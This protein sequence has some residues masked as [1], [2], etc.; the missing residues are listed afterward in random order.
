MASILIVSSD[1]DAAQELQGVAREAGA[2]AR[3]VNSPASAREWLSMS[4]FDFMLVDAA[5][6]ERTA[7]ALLSVGWKYSDLM[8]I[9]IFDLYRDIP[10]QWDA[11]LLGA[12]VFSGPKALASIR[13]GIDNLNLSEPTTSEFPILLV[14]DLDSPREI[15][16]SY[17]ESMG[18]KKVEDVKDAQTALKLLEEKPGAFSCIV[19]DMNMPQMS[20]AELIQ[21]IRRDETLHHLPVIVLTAYS[22]AENLLKCIK[23]GATG[24]LVKPPRKKALR[25]ELEKARRVY[26]GRQSPRLCS[27]DDAHLLE[28]ALMRSMRQ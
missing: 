12:L 6:G 28:R 8:I 3:V 22:T 9:G 11:A 25:M 20:G 4:E 18:Y 7:L 1:P 16:R 26:F 19:T 2:R 14:E 13:A 21:A 15:I 10:Y 24:F 17:I 23:A 27:P 5:L